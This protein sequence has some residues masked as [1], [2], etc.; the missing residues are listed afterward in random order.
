MES[1]FL[2]VIFLV[3]ALAQGCFDTNGVEVDSTPCDTGSLPT[4]CCPSNTS[5]VSPLSFRE[6]RIV[7]VALRAI[8]WGYRHLSKLCTLRT[9]A[10]FH[11]GFEYDFRIE[12]VLMLGR[13]QMAYVKETIS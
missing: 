5:C 12:Y 13:C 1:L 3:E 4:F 8:A 6:P 7:N 11:G 9:T 2:I 10:V